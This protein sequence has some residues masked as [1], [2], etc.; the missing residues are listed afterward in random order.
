LNEALALMHIVV[1]I[2]PSDEPSQKPITRKQLAQKLKCHINSIRNDELLIKQ[3]VDDA[4][5][6]YCNQEGKLEGIEL[7]PYLIWL[8]LKVR[9]L[10]K[11]YRTEK[12]LEKHIFQ[13]Q[14]LFSETA[15]NEY[16]EQQQH[17]QARRTG[18]SGLEVA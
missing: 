15:F 10:R 18:T 14:Q 13:N 2:E 9:S 1:T 6:Y 17:R 5:A 16:I 4:Q 7:S 8:L 11:K 12:G 3:W